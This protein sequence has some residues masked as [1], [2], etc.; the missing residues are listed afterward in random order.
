M[1]VRFGFGLFNVLESAAMWILHSNFISKC[2]YYIIY[3][4]KETEY[5]ELIMNIMGL[6]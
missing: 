6:L 2:N 4:M 3:T 1:S 5:Y